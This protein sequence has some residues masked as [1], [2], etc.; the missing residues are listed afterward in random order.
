[1]GFIPLSNTIPWLSY[2]EIVKFMLH[3]YFK[4]TYLLINTI[5]NEWL[6]LLRI[7]M[8]LVICS[9]DIKCWTMWDGVVGWCKQWCLNSYPTPPRCSVQWLS[10][11]VC[12]CVMQYWTLKNFVFLSQRPLWGFLSPMFSTW[13]FG[14]IF[15]KMLVIPCRLYCSSFLMSQHRW[16]WLDDVVD[17]ADLSFKLCSSTL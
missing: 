4:V 1:M 2:W 14:V 15:G 12:F 5:W 10:F 6:S 11:V 17:T 13:T 9:H 8:K 7:S 3:W 16:A